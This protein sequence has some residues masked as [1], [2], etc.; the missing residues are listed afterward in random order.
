MEMIGDM[1]G[2]RELIA[3]GARKMT[4]WD[5]PFICGDNSRLKTL[6]WIPRYSLHDG[7]S[8]VVRELVTIAV[9]SASAV[10]D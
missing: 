3:F 5:P 9:G 10:S 7:L 1:L 4:G 8:K 6:G 2:A